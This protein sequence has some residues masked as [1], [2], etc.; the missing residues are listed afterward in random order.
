LSNFWPAVWLAV[1]FP[2]LLLALNESIAVC[3]RRGFAVERTGAE[4]GRALPVRPQALRR[5]VSNLV[6][7]A[8]RHAGADLPVELAMGVGTG[9]FHIDVRDRGPGIPADDVERIK[10]PFVRLESARS[11]AVGAGL[12]LAIVKT[13]LDACGGTVEARNRQP[14]GFEV[15]LRLPPA[16]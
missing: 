16:A 14:R 2:L 6:D 10:R 3:R 9:G 1:G 11:N 15:L 13:C 8:L 12:G 7:N 5:A 4:G